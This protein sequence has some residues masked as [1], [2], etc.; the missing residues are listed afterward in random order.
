MSQQGVCVGGAP[1]KD[2]QELHET[3]EVSGSQAARCIRVPHQEIW[4]H[5]VTPTKD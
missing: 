5:V 2:Q 1:L 4:R 3:P